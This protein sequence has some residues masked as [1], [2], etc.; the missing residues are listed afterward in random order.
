MAN[1]KHF[2]NVK[3][4]HTYTFNIKIQRVIK[5]NRINKIIRLNNIKYFQFFILDIYYE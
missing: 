5:N 2:E 1:I 4:K 3:T